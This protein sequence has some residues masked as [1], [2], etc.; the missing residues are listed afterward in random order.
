M[1]QHFVLAAAVL[2]GATLVYRSAV[3]AGPARAKPPVFSDDVVD[4]FFP[5]ARKVLQGERP[6]F[7]GAKNIAKAGGPMA[8]GAAEE[9]AGGGFAW[10]KL[11]SATTLED[12]IKAQKMAVDKTVDTPGGFKGGGYQ[13]A[14]IEF[15]VL[16]AM[17]H[18]AGQYD[19]DV[20]WKEEAPGLRDLFA[21]AGF[22]CKVGTDQSYKEAALRKQDLGDLIR[23]GTVSAKQSEAGVTWDKVTDR[24][25]LM[26]RFQM[27]DKRISPWLANEKEFSAHAEDILHEAEVLAAMAEAI[28]REGFEFW[29]DEDYVGYAANMR[30]AALKVAQGVKQNN[31]E[32]ASAAAG[33]L[34]KAC[35]TCHDNYR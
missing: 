24:P 25:P 3:G 33:E 1:K 6:V 12:E 27:A 14:R 11:I 7:A 18:V 28:Q 4:T 22:N 31:Y 17:F 19:K 10:S 34:S 21:R 16:A 8:G 9:S 20:R 32:A 30:D 35:G 5:D 15:S 23:G 26:N 2:A 13:D 29:E